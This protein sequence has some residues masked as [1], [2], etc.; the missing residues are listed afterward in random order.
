MQLEITQMLKRLYQTEKNLNT[1]RSKIFQVKERMIC[2][3]VSAEIQ[4]QKEFS[5]QRTNKEF[6]ESYKQHLLIEDTEY[7]QLKQEHHSLLKQIE[8]LE[9]YRRYLERLY[10]LLSNGIIGKEVIENVEL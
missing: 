10:E 7:Q 3:E 6:R 5:N 4:V 9:A 8:D 2:K 1:L